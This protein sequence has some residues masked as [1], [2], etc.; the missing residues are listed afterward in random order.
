MSIPKKVINLYISYALG[1]QLKTVN[2]DFTLVNCLFGSVR[3]WKKCYGKNVIIFGPDM[4]SSVHFDNKA[5]DILII[6]EEP[7]KGLDDTTLTA[8]PKHPVNFTQ[9]GKRFSLSLHYNGNNSFLFVNARKAC[10]FKAKKNRNK[11]LS[12]VFR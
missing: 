8:E 4:S 6:G 1:A 3:I 10:Q 12:I 11:K 7:T 9:S 5:K 2:T